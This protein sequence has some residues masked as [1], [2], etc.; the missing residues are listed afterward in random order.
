VE[1]ENEGIK[2]DKNLSL[3]RLKTFLSERSLAAAAVN[4]TKI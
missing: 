4:K 2:S 3:R 1:Q